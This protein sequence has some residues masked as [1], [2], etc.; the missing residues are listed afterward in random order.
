MDAGATGYANQLTHYDCYC[1]CYGKEGKEEDTRGTEWT[2]IEA[3]RTAHTFCSLR[4]D[5][6]RHAS[7]DE[8]HDLKPQKTPAKSHKKKETINTASLLSLQHGYTEVG[9]PI[10]MLA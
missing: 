3:S 5:T 4:Q 2:R 6:I 8:A 7:H 9:P 10:L 1:D